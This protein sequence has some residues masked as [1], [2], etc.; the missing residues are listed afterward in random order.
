MD[1]AWV[2]NGIVNTVL[3]PIWPRWFYCIR[4]FYFQWIFVCPIN[5]SY[6]YKRQCLHS[7]SLIDKIKASR[8]INFSIK[9]SKLIFSLG[10]QFDKN[11][12]TIWRFQV[13]SYLGSADLNF[14]TPLIKRWIFSFLIQVLKLR[15]SL[16]Y[17]SSVSW[18]MPYS[19]TLLWE[20]TIR[21]SLNQ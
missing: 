19:W 13:E 15:K 6:I 5:I 17:S 16:T 9:H 1:L 8:V 12:K 4:N 7:I 18:V 14:T 20:T 10:Y 21:Y 11:S 3:F 2:K